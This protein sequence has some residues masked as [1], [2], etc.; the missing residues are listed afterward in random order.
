MSH[1]TI[2]VF[3]HAL[4]VI[5]AVGANFTCSVLLLWSRRQPEGTVYILKAIR[6]L[7]SRVAIPA[8]VLVLL[9]GLVMVLA[10]PFPIT[11]PWILTGLALYVMIVVLGIAAYAPAF[12]RQMQIASHDGIQSDTYRREARL[13]SGFLGA[14]TVLAVLSVFLMVAKP[15]LWA[16]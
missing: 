3:L 12:R 1:F 4:S 16:G 13:A 10:V 6:M 15:P 9:T 11:T 7:D 8:Y 2:T 14:V 5:V